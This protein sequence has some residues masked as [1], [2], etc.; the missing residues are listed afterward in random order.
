[1]QPYL[2]NSYYSDNHEFFED[3]QEVALYDAM[4]RETDPAKQRALMRRFEKRVL[5]EET[6]ALQ[7]LW[8]NRIIPYRSYVKG[9]KISPNHYVNQDLATIWL[10]M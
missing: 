3:P 8:W 6:H 5:D 1:M 4:L 7:I 9:W 2:P 10:D